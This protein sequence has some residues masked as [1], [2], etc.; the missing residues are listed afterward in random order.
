M[1]KYLIGLILLLITCLGVIY[2]MYS[3]QRQK[4]LVQERN[5][6]AL[7]SSVEYFKTESGQNAAKI[8][9]LELNLNSYKKLYSDSYREVSE[10]K[11]KLKNATSVIQYVTE[12][13]Y[14]NKDSIIYVQDPK[15]K[16]YKVRDSL[17]SADIITTGDSLIKPGNFII[18]SIR[19]KTT[20]IPNIEY[21][22]WWL[23]KKPKG[24]YLTVAN[25]NP[26]IEVT[27]ILYIDL[28]KNKNK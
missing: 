8:Q 13:K 15:G 14:K 1:K 20:V 11:V 23:W 7:R 28:S 9:G 4:V 22:G 18:N 25:T 16:L 12:I 19:N 27:D 24:V 26:F 3:K 17:V 10:L 2:T 5:I 6:T 21:K